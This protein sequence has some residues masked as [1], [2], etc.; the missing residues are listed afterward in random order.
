MNEE[1][2][3]SESLIADGTQDSSVEIKESTAQEIIFKPDNVPDDF[4][5]DEKKSLK[6]DDLLKS[7]SELDK[8]AKGLRE[9][10]SKGM[11]N[12]PDDPKGYEFQME[13]QVLKDLE[14]EELNA[15]MVDMAKSAA[16]E[17][18]LSKEQFNV[19]MTKIIPQLH[20]Y[21]QVLN[22][23]EPTQEEIEQQKQEVESYKK[24]ERSKLGDG[25]DR[26]IESVKAHLNTIKR[27][28]VFSES[29]VDLIQNGLG[30]SA[31]GIMILNKMFT[32]MFGETSRVSDF[33]A[34]PS[35]FGVVTKD[36][37]MER[38]NDQRNATN[39]AFY[40]ETQRM[41]ERYGEQKKRAS[42]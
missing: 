25:A 30:A 29:E 33:N 40:E 38:L 12:V 9:K 31:D 24:Q 19:F 22:Q 14:V 27:Q 17:A 37:L 34:K 1:A 23:R 16:L 11:Q 35:S 21:E 3:L 18:G 13:E 20:E 15:D 39:S 41:V 4:W 42:K 2:L 5:D 6:T 26:I 10:L 28:N 36:S 7:Y 32:K 8:R